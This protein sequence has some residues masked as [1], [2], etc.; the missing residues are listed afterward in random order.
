M[1]AISSAPD[2]ATLEIPTDAWTQPFWDAT[3]NKTLAAPR[4]SQCLRFRWPPG[5]F[6]PVCQSQA[7]QWIAISE[8]RIY[9]FAIIPAK[10][11]TSMPVYRV[12]ALIELPLADGIRIL[13]P[14]VDTP[15]GAIRIGA[16][17]EVRWHMTAAGT[18]PMFCVSGHE[19]S[20]A[21][22]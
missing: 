11:E 14:I 13:A 17:V 5:P 19:R 18:L 9:S 12:P 15:L 1:S 3:A 4:C 7:V 8:A 22:R 21:S 6:C 10:S 20:S 2:V 16:P